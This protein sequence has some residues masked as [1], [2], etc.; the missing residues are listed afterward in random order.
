MAFGIMLLNGLTQ[1]RERKEGMPSTC[2]WA[3][4]NYL[5]FPI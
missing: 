3:L 4:E 1:G 5:L 2:W